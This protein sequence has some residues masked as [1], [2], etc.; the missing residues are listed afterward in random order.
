MTVTR[1]DPTGDVDAVV[2]VWVGDAGVAPHWWPN[3]SLFQGFGDEVLDKVSIG[4]GQPCPETA[5]EPAG[6]VDVEMF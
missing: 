6:W 4:V 5:T 2:E 1:E 3:P